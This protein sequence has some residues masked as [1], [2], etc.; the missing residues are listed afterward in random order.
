MS[1]YERLYLA[2]FEKDIKKIKTNLDL[3]RRL[4]SKVEEILKDP[5]HYKPLRNV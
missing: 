3:R 1:S 4:Q 5:Y 2:Q